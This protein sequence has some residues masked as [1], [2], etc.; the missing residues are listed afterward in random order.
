MKSVAIIGAGPSGLA[1]A[2]YAIENGLEPVVFDKSNEACG[3][4]S[5]DSI[6]ENYKNMNVNFSRFTYSFTDFPWPNQSPI[7]PTAKEIKEYL[8]SYIHHFKLTKHLKM[9]TK[10]E[11][12]ELLSNE[13][14]KVSFMSSDSTNSNNAIES[15]VFD[16]VIIAS[17]RHHE[18][19]MPIIRGRENFRGPVL[20]SSE[21]IKLKEPIFKNKKV[22]V[23]GASWN[24]TCISA[25][26]VNDGAKSIS[27]IF[28]RPYL[29]LPKLVT[30]KYQTDET[31]DH[32]AYSIV[33]VDVALFTR[34]QMYP[35]HDVTDH[36]DIAKFYAQILMSICPEQTNQTLSHPELYVDLLR[37]DG[38]KGLCVNDSYYSFV[39][40]GRIN[41]RKGNI[42]EFKEDG[43][44]LDDGSFEQADAVVFC[45]GFYINQTF[46]PQEILNKL[47]YTKE[48]DENN[49]PYIL[50]KCTWHPDLP[51][52]ALIGQNDALIFC[53][54]EL[55]AN[56]ATS[57]IT[58]F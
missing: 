48:N 22:I 2:K 13:K 32:D 27:N 12:I 16:S 41:P 51:N 29:V 24:A 49:V 40:S 44:Q 11:K 5:N 4:W 47:E 30:K 36:Q 46:L 7:F 26:L 50:Y 6:N 34:A 19:K 8:Q 42:V 45:T 52:L 37:D 39:K 33:P 55:Q 25:L 18:P 14:W 56:W 31:A 54:S 43:V 58:F 21:F 28:R 17:G 15:K 35:P 57:V 1:S 53:G 3:V 20:H 38:E 9:K 10:V 23:V